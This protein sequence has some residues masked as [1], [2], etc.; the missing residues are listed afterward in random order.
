MNT[1][2]WD[3][4]GE[5]NPV[6]FSCNYVFIDHLSSETTGGTCGWIWD[7]RTREETEGGRACLLE[8]GMGVCPSQVHSYEVGGLPI[9]V[10]FWN[11]GCEW[12]MGWCGAWDTSRDYRS[13]TLVINVVL[14]T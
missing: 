12:G 9:V 14:R 5:F 2:R 3:A 10:V 6:L 1:A 7:G 11:K 4:G 8:L 13:S